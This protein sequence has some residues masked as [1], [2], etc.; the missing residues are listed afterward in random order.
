MKIDIEKIVYN[1]AK[2]ANIS[3]RKDALRL[4]KDAYSKE[5]NSKPKQALKIILENASFAKRK[6]LAICQ[7]TGLPIV[8]IEAGKSIQVGR[9]F[10]DKVNKGLEKAY[11]KEGFRASTVDPFCSKCSFNPE[12]IHVEFTKTRMSRITV[13][14]KGFGSEN[15]SKLKMFN[16]T[17]TRKEITQFIVDTVKEAGPAACPPFFVGVGIGGTADKALFLAKKALLDR[18]DKRVRDISLR[19]WEEDIL[20]K[21]NLLNI[22]PMGL[23]GKFTALSVR[24]KT[25]PTHI[26][27]LPV[28]VNISCHALRSAAVEL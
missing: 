16:P 8:F 15:K 1:L 6:T 3:L 2:K 25:Y 24:I 27:G 11:E 9:P 4:I 5:R 18:L 20:K 22:G 19:K 23:G 7:D 10:V 17:A 21:I 28:G 14:P 13:F 12:I 26:A